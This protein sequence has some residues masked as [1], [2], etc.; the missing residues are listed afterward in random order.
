EFV[1]ANAELASDPSLV[2]N[3]AYDRGWFYEVRGQVEPDAMDVDRYVCL[4][5]A[6]IDRMLE[7]ASQ[8]DAACPVP[9]T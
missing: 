6:T 8:G 2:E 3:D 5:D 7:Q 4:L 9:G 1:R